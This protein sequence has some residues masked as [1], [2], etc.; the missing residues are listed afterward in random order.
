MYHNKAS[1][2]KHNSRMYCTAIIFSIIIR[3]ILTV[4]VV[5]NQSWLTIFI[6][7]SVLYTEHGVLPLTVLK[8][9]NSKQIKMKISVWI[10][11]EQCM[12][13][14]GSSIKQKKS[15]PHTPKKCPI[16]ANHLSHL[17]N[18]WTL[19]ELF[20]WRTSFSTEQQLDGFPSRIPHGLFNL[21]HLAKEMKTEL[22]EQVSWLKKKTHQN[23]NRLW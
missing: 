6:H 22:R 17:N 11:N 9:I 4:I 21:L 2:Y 15:N 3:I 8:L 12:T 1:N 13:H 23:T 5:K 18:P 10:T 7:S 20:V 16:T 19:R 14:F